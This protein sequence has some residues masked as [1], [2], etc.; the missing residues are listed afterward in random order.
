VPRT[1]DRAYNQ[2]R[3]LKCAV[4]WCKKKRRGLARHCTTHENNLKRN[5]HV[6]AWSIRQ[7]AFKPYQARVA[8]FLQEHGSEP[9]VRQAERW[10][11]GLIASG[12]RD[13]V[14]ESSRQTRGRASSTLSDFLKRLCAK[15]VSGRELLERVGA[16][17]LL[18]W[19]E[20]LSLP[21]DDRLTFALAK[22]IIYTRPLRGR[23]MGTDKKGRR[24]HRAPRPQGATLQALGGHLREHLGA[25][26]AYLVA[27]L[28]VQDKTAAA[29]VERVGADASA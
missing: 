26:A 3:Q 2:N 16:V 17:W 15:E 14:E 7:R 18:S 10:L 23:F 13:L 20:P 5:G 24:K 28:E 19:R 8:V 9:V 22:S 1:V 4:E 6:K 12:G 25:F 21:D 29:S 27:G 11:A